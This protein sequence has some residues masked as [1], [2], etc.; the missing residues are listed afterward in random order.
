MLTVYFSILIGGSAAI[1]LVLLKE[2][3]IHPLRAAVDWFQDIFFFA[4]RHFSRISFQKRIANFNKTRSEA[5]AK[6]LPA[7]AEVKKPESP[8]TKV[9][10][11]TTEIMTSLSHE[12]TFVEKRFQERFERMEKLLKEKSELLEK[13]ERNL[14]YEMMNRREFTTVKEL[15]ENQMIELKN[16]NQRLSSDLTKMAKEREESHLL[17][18]LLEEKMIT[19]DKQISE[20]NQKLETQKIQLQNFLNFGSD[21]MKEI[22]QTQSPE[23]LESTPDEQNSEL[24][25]SRAESLEPTNVPTNRQ[26]QDVFKAN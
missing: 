14:E 22:I 24:D 11:I 1:L 18:K 10:K 2:F 19:Q 15:L 8:Q 25:K 5:R 4:D 21:R 6:G 12:A 17:M 13:T 16:Q 20:K 9:E 23:L 3:H 26:S 7:T